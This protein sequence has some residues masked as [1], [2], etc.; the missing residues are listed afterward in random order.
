MLSRYYART[1]G[2]WEKYNDNTQLKYIDEKRMESSNQLFEITDTINFILS[3]EMGWDS[4]IREYKLK[5][6][7]NF[8]YEDLIKNP[9]DHINIIEKCLGLHKSTDKDLDMGKDK[10]T[11]KLKRREEAN[12]GRQLILRTVGLMEER[13][14]LMK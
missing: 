2:L 7:E 4:Y 6:I 10:I 14:G 5:V 8:Y 13:L 11:Q 12:R 1:T 9:V 3:S